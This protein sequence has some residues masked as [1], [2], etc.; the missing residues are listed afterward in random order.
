MAQNEK[1]KGTIPART[2]IGG[3]T[4]PHGAIIA[5]PD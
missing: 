1:A 4:P 3:K 2:C 5:H